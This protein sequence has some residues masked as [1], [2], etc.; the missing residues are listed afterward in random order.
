MD[1]GGNATT[2]VEEEEEEGS[3]PK[4]PEEERESPSLH[5]GPNG[6][7]SC[8]SIHKEEEEEWTERERGACHLIACCCVAVHLFCGPAM[9][10]KVA[11]AAV[12]D[13]DALSQ[14]A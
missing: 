7:T 3:S 5:L 9:V 10:V 14:T 13:K 11:V 4:V 12:C 8:W 1:K 2:K 6:I